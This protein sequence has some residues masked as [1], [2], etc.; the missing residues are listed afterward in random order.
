M[1]KTQERESVRVEVVSYV[2]QYPRCGSDNEPTVKQILASV[3]AD[4]PN[5]PYV[6]CSKCGKE[7]EL[8]PPENLIIEKDDQLEVLCRKL[9]EACERM[10]WALHGRA[11]DER[12]TSILTDADNLLSKA[13]KA[14]IIT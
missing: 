7:V 10:S 5:P 9:A 8:L 14:G 11:L 2:W 13:R 6:K 1:S 3:G 4:F 12:E